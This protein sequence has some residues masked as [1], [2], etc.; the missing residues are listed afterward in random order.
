[1]YKYLFTIFGLFI[2]CGA[3]NPAELEA[4]KPQFKKTSHKVS[5]YQKQKSHQR[6]A[7]R[8]S[9]NNSNQR[10]TARKT[11]NYVNAVKPYQNPTKNHPLQISR[12]N[13]KDVLDSHGL[14]HQQAKNQVNRY[15]Q[16]KKDKQPFVVITGKGNH[17]QHRPFK[18]KDEVSNGIQ[19]NNR[20]WKVI[21]DP[22]NSGRIIVQPK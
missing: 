4:G 19:Q 12:Q 8:K 9:Q 17:G 13:G 1:M 6:P 15:L 14:T 21:N 2:V 18:M 22:T 10:A 20:N 3:F 11:Q 5:G 7:I 16:S